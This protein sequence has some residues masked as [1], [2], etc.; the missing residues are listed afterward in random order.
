MLVLLFYLVSGLRPVYRSLIIWITVLELIVSLTFLLIFYLY[1]SPD[2]FIQ[3]LGVIALI[4]VFFFVAN[5]W[6]YAVLISVFLAAVFLVIANIR[7]DYIS[8]SG[9]AA[10]GVYLALVLLISAISSYRINYYKRMQY[11]Y[12]RELKLASEI[13]ALTGIYIK[14]KFNEEL[15]KWMELAN[16]H[17][18]ALSLV[19]F[20]I[21]DLKRIND[22]YGHLT[23][24]Q[25][26]STLAGIVKS[27]V[28]QSDIFARWGGDEFAI[29]L[30]HTDEARAYELAKRIRAVI[31]SHCFE[32]VGSISCSFGVAVYQKGDDGNS[33]LSRADQKLYQAK[34]TGKNLV[35]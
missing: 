21:D 5:R 31:A 2:F 20:D 19:L 14:A 3:S 9:L 4:V 25:V 35:M 30:P 24:E 29:L 1:E 32:G 13:D 23:G 22:E 12:N 26:L 8:P 33:F 6:L 7:F 34:S 16:R 28:R 10:V 17:D 27:V 11:L 18:Q 15:H